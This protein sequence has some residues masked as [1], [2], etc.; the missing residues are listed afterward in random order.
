M[1]LLISNERVDN[2]DKVKL[3]FSNDF[4]DYLISSI[5]STFIENQISPVAKNDKFEIIGDW[6]SLLNTFRGI[7]GKASRN[8][9]KIEYNDNFSKNIIEGL[10]KKNKKVKAQDRNRNIK[11]KNL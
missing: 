4:P 3:K 9:F 2:I 6:H 11:K 7:V 5:K 8:N 1:K 10:I